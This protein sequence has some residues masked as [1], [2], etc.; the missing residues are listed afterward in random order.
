MIKITDNEHE[1]QEEEII[2]GIIIDADYGFGMKYKDTKNLYLK[3]EIQQYDGWVSTQLFREDK[4][5]KLLQQFK[6]DYRTDSGVKS[7][8]HQAIYSLAEEKINGVP[9]AVCVL[10]PKRYPQYE[11]I[12]NDNW[13]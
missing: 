7:L 11:W 6:G 1:E 12:Y 4:I 8:V 9:Q 5:A 10:P 13:D 3:L 2:E